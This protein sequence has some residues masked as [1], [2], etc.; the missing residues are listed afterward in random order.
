MLGQVILITPPPHQADTEP[1]AR[2]ESEA[3]LGSACPAQPSAG[4]LSTGVQ[5][6]AWARRAAL[7]AWRR[8]KKESSFVLGHTVPRRLGLQPE[9]T[10]PGS[11]PSG[12]EG[13][14]GAS[15][16]FSQHHAAWTATWLTCAYGF[17]WLP[18]RPAGPLATCHSLKSRTGGRR[19]M[20]HYD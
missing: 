9:L 20:G 13:C 16:P 11:T 6:V 14:V 8:V 4:P 12:Q 10:A 7:V 19:G 1:V 18:S 5:E 17:F 2:H 3:I 15:G